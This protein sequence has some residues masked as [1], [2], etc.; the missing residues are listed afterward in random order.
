MQRALDFPASLAEKYR[1]R[2]IED[3]AGLAKP[4]KVL[5]RFARAP[6]SMAFLF[7]GPSGTGK[8]T[9][10]LA[11][12]EQLPAELTHIPS[13]EC[14]LGTV[15]EIARKC[16]YFPW[17]GKFHLVLVDEADQMTQPAQLAFLSKLDSTAFPP[18]TIF[19]FTANDT[20]RL[21]TRFLSRLA[22]LDF[23]SYGIASDAVKLL[24]KVWRSEGGNGNAPNFARI[25]KDSCNNLRDALMK[26][27]VELLAAE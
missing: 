21:E 9:M 27:E 5:C 6:R 19:V 3:F 17:R 26:L 16:H 13:R 10:A 25:V 4:K 2:R 22:Q 14:D 11:L 15:Q 12:A 23:S 18:N 20:E 8:T 7:L 24:D 1:P